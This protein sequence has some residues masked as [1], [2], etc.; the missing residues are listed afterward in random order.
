VRGNGLQ[1]LNP[2]LVLALPQACRRASMGDQLG[3]PDEGVIP[4]PSVVMTYLVKHVGRQITEDG[5]L[6]VNGEPHRD[7]RFQRSW[8]L[9]SQNEVERA[10]FRADSVR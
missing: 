1:C 4:R 8:N 9:T 6:V 7:S 5:E 10:C 2:Y 3:K